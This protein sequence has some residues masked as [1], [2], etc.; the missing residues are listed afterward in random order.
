MLDKYRANTR[1]AVDLNDPNVQ[2]GEVVAEPLSEEL[3]ERLM[4]VGEAVA[5]VLITDPTH[6][7][8]RTTGDVDLLAQVLARAD[9]HG[10]DLDRHR[11]RQPM[12]ASGSLVVHRRRGLRSSSLFGR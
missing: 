8:T 2:M 12:S 4:N 10:L 3:R 11:G 5:G 7:A 6:P 1:L 9:D